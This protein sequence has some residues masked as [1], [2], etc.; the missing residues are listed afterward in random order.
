[1][2]QQMN[3]LA[4]NTFG[5]YFTAV[6]LEDGSYL[7]YKHDKPKL[8]E[9]KVV[10]KSALMAFLLPRTIPVTIL[11]QCGKQVLTAVAMQC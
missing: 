9:S 11:P 3:Q 5:F 6:Q 10:Y 7:Y 8:S 4:A 1:M 2:V